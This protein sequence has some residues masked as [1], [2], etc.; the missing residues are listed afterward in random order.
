MWLKNYLKFLK[1]DLVNTT[2]CL[3]TIY[4][5]HE[6]YTLNWHSQQVNFFFRFIN[7]LASE[8]NGREVENEC[9]TNE[10][11]RER[12]SDVWS[13]ISGYTVGGAKL[14]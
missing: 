11:C 6:C 5:I 13:A 10:T 8:I 7:V 1:A 12:S 4:P 3:N 2:L 14:I 9:G